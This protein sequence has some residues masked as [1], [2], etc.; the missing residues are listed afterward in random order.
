MFAHDLMGM[1]KGGFFQE[2]NLNPR[3]HSRAAILSIYQKYI[4]L[5]KVNSIVSLLV[6]SIVKEQLIVGSTRGI[7]FPEC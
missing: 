5:G 6:S 4:K 7:L 1:G 3:N 2:K